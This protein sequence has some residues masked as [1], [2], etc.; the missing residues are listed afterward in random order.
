[1]DIIPNL[2]SQNELLAYLKQQMRD[3]TGTTRWQ[4]VEYYNTLNNAVRRWGKVLLS[5]LKAVLGVR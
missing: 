5:I 4:P 3:T 1:M 2:R